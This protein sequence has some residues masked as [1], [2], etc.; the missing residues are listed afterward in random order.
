MAE[1]PTLTVPTVE[2]RPVDVVPYV[3]NRFLLSGAF[4]TKGDGLLGASA[5]L[6]RTGNDLASISQQLAAQP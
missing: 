2:S 4:G 5:G 3:P 1:V 6:A